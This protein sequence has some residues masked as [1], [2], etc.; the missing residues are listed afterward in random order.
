MFD[1]QLVTV[2]S[3]P[4][5]VLPFSRLSSL[6]SSLSLLLLPSLHNLASLF[7]FHLS[8]IYLPSSKTTDSSRSLSSSYLS[9]R[10][11]ALV[12][13]CS[14]CYRCGNLASIMQVGDN[15]KTTFKTFEAA[16]ENETDERNPASR[17]TVRLP[18]LLPLPPLFPLSLQTSV[19]RTPLSCLPF[20]PE[21][22]RGKNRLAD[23][24]A[25][26]FFASSGSTFVLRIVPPPP[27]EVVNV[28][29]VVSPSRPI[30]C[31][32]FV[33]SLDHLLAFRASLLHTHHLLEPYCMPFPSRSL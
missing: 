28:G 9:C 15:G 23:W 14:Y 19:G 5:C 16:P 7:S 6:I 12:T 17:R 8:R 10:P 33:V 22:G 21:E 26:S 2:W 13:S 11:S 1:N 24:S 29:P 18:S 4:K 25:F 3:A 30:S 32:L 27:F 31:V 20:A